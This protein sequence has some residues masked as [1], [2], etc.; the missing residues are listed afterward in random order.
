MNEYKTIPVFVKSVDEDEGI[1]T[2]LISVYGIVD[3]GGDIAHKGMF[4]KTI[5]ERGAKIRVVDNHRR[6][7]VLDVVGK[8]LNFYEVTKAE[9][10]REVLTRYPDATGGMMVE[11]QFLLDTPEGKGIFSRIKN[12]A[13]SEFSYGYNTM[14]SD[15]ENIEGKRIRHLRAVRLMEYGPTIFGMNDAAVAVSAKSDEEQIVVKIRDAD[16]EPLRTIQVV[17]GTVEGKTAIRSFGFDKNEWTEEEIKDLGLFR[18][19]G[20]LSRAFDRQFDWEYS[21]HD[22]YEQYIVATSYESPYFFRVGYEQDEE[23][24][25][26]FTE[27]DEWEMGTLEFVAT[28]SE[29][30]AK[31]RLIEYEL[32]ML[33]IEAG[34]VLPP[35]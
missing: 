8:P 28:E 27:R 31:L 12:D 22:V 18:Q 35:T 4:T 11:T 23:G 14:D 15:R 2:H 16:K 10:P 30:D 34:P 26:T 24:S 29:A 32:A 20:S 21:L 5:Q 19:L 33:D 7:S 1:V 3:K 6:E 17:V 9:L 25:Y 13:I